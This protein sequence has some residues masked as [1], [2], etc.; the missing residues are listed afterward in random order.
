M[1]VV[2]KGALVAIVV[3]ALA[4]VYAGYSFAKHENGK[5]SVIDR[6]ADYGEE[7]YYK[8]HKGGGVE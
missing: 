1:I 3:V 6:L 8:I 5:R 2:A 4:A 7:L